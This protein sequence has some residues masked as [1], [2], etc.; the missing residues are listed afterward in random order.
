M[1]QGDKKPQKHPHGRHHRFGL[2]NPLLL[3]PCAHAL[4]E[5]VGLKAFRLLTKCVQERDDR[6]TVILEGGVGGAPMHP[7]P[8][9]K[10]HKERGGRGWRGPRGCWRDQP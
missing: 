7:H 4:P 8:V 9:L 10:G 5:R 3:C 1:A 6:S 2:C